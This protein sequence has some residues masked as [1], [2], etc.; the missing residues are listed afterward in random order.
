[1]VSSIFA[2]KVGE[3]VDYGLTPLNSPLFIQD[4]RAKIIR[5][6]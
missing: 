6:P 4:A 3:Y 5:T 1:M 2:H